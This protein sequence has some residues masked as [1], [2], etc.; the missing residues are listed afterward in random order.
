MWKICTYNTDRDRKLR[1]AIIKQ[2]IL[3]TKQI[4]I[5][6]NSDNEKKIRSIRVLTST[7]HKGKGNLCYWFNQ[8][9]SGAFANARVNENRR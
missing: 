5:A 1:S 3:W 6:M 9:C 7:L 4:L 2:T 8:K